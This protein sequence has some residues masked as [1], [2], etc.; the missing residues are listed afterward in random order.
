MISCLYFLKKFLTLE[1]IDLLRIIHLLFQVF[2][3]TVKPRVS[4]QTKG[5]TKFIYYV[6]DPKGKDVK[7]RR[8]EARGIMS[9]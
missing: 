2:P 4:F 8:W 5:A 9:V 1:F 3:K 7:G 6:V